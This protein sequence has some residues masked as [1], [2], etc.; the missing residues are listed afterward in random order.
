MFEPFIPDNFE[1]P[2]R[3]DTES[4]HLRVLEEA[5]AELDF[6]AVVSS[7]QRLQGV[8]GPESEWPK[9]SMTLEE[10][11]ESLKVHK[12]EF[13]SRVAFAYS[14]FNN[15][16]DTCLGSVYIDPSQSPKYDC[17]V[18]LWVR[19]DAIALDIALYHTV[20][21]WLK[22]DWPFSKVAFPGRSISWA[23]WAVALKVT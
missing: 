7:Q 10:N 3:F 4:F 18:Y 15:S 20:F 14:V 12:R 1:A 19:D 21:D 6:D 11:T 8:F 5:V 13:E 16:K 22:K 9:P 2:K 17:E 23:D